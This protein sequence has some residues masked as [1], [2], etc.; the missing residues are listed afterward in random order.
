MLRFVASRLLQA[1]LSLLVASIAIFG[2]ARLSG[3][4]ADV[5]LGTEAT[6]EERAAFRRHMGLDRP[7]PVQYVRYLAA[8][9]RGDFGDSLR[10]RRPAVEIVTYHLV[11][12]LKLVT[13]AM[14]ITLAFSVPVGVLAATRRGTLWD[15]I[16][17]GSA[18]LGQSLPHFW[19]GIMAIFVF[20]AVLGW[21]PSSGMGGWR[22]YL[23]PA[24]VM[25]WTL[26]AAIVRLLRSG[27]LD[28]LDSE[29]VK[30]A[31]CKGLREARVVWKHALRNAVIPLVTFVGYTYGLLI[32]SAFAI[33]VVFAWPGLGRLAVDSVFW[34]DYPV[35]QLS[36]LLWATLIIGLNL[37]TDVVYGCLDPRI[38]QAG[39]L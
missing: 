6:Q 38:R 1:V 32:A 18:V 19:V 4:P 29:Y 9:V 24:A 36:V 8:A 23:L 22:H 20:S 21:L 28:V 33:E 34:R 13:V 3:D 7:I 30:L 25:G 37:I 26:S 31:R 2:L 17:R 10:T 5:M 11:N 39:T 16:A 12:S 27:M 15:V 14:I 35:L